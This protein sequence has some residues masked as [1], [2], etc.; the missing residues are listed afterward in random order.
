MTENI[1]STLI[2]DAVAIHT[3]VILGASNKPERYANMA[4]R[5]L[6]KQG[7]RV[8]PV[9]PKIRKIEGIAVIHHLRDITEPVHTL[10]MYVGANRSYELLHDILRLN[11][12]RV[13]FNPD[14]ES[15]E[16]E[17]QLNSQNILTIQGCT[18]VML[19]TQQF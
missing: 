8:I 13:I 5:E 1:S 10:T 15:P 3:V 14:T 7:Y 6:M 19:K 9:H 11:P 2:P 16:L 4:Q 17:A 12:Q 18:L